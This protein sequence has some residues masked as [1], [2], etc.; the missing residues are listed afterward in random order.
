[1]RQNDD[2]H[3]L[4]IFQLNAAGIKDF[5]V[6]YRFAYKDLGREFEWD[7]AFVDQKIAVEV[8]GGIW[9]K[10]AHGHPITILRNMEKGNWGAAL[11]WRVLAFSTDQVK[12]GEALNFIE[13]VLKNEVGGEQHGKALLLQA[14]A[15]R[16]ARS[17]P[18]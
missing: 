16:S 8:N 15:K 14:A 13:A 11:G 5:H 18:S 17:R 6:E 7:L 10:G 9:T 4:L 2:A 3:R 1:M 12:N